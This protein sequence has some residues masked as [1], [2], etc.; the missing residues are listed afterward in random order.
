M[1]FIY[2]KSRFTRTFA[3]A[4]LC[5]LLAILGWFACLYFGFID[6]KELERDN[7]Y[8]L[9][10]NI[11]ISNIQ[12]TQTDNLGVTGATLRAFTKNKAEY[13][14]VTYQEILDLV[15][16]FSDIRIKSTLYYEAFLVFDNAFD[17]MMTDGDARLTFVGISSLNAVPDFDPEQGASSVT[18]FD[19]KEGDFSDAED[20]II[21]V[22]EWMLDE[23]ERDED[24]NVMPLILQIALSS[25]TGGNFYE[26]EADISGY[27]SGPESNTVY[28]SW[29]LAA[30]IMEF[31]GHQPSAE[32]ISATVADN[33]KLDEL[34]ELLSHY[35]SEVNPAGVSEQNPYS[36]FGEN[37]RFAAIV[38]DEMLRET[39]S[40]LNRSISTLKRLRPVVIALELAISAV[41]AYFYIHTRKRELA[42]A[43]SLGTPRKAVLLTLILEM[44]IW[45]V[46]AS[47]VAIVASLATPLCTLKP[48]A[49]AAVVVAALIGTLVSGYQV[50]GRTGILSLKEEN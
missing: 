45:C 50:T 49:I 29:E 3:G 40:S 20:F 41:S 39:L 36:Y 16:Y 44:L 33:T 24:G 28:C 4:V 25:E 23:I 15:P 26:L 10:V 42:I 43:R 1:P 27:Y 35:F 8:S 30:H 21:I 7:A 14:G 34:R 18:L 11:V 38:H 31:L 17:Y 46:L 22:P 13:D 5:L 2:L 6:S 9:P 19:G 48:T 12:G 32:C 37:Y 47:L